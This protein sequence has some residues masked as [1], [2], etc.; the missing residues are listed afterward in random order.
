MKVSTLQ[1]S[2][3]SKE[4]QKRVVE[5]V[6][7]KSKHKH[8]HKRKH[9]KDYNLNAKESEMSSSSPNDKSSSKET[10]EESPSP[11]ETG[12]SCLNKKG[13]KCLDAHPSGLSF[14]EFRTSM[15]GCNMK[16]QLYTDEEVEKIFAAKEEAINPKKKKNI[17]LLI[18]EDLIKK[19]GQIYYKP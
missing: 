15:A 1:Q 8:K 12:T 5:I 14:N 11:A 17:T 10:E 3:R 2:E 7:P 4:K 19:P 6:D 16:I 9:K 18:P 13:S